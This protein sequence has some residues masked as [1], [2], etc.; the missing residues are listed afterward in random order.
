MPGKIFA[1]VGNPIL[2]SKSPEMF[3]AAF[4]KLKINAIYIRIAAFDAEEV[5][6]TADDIG[7]CGLNIT[8]PFKEE[9]KKKMRVSNSL[10]TLINTIIIDKN[11]REIDA[12]NC[13]ICKNDPKSKCPKKQ[14]LVG[15]NTD[16]A[17]VIGALKHNSCDFVGKKIIV[18]GAGGAAKAAIYALVSKKADV[19]VVN[20]TFKK[21][22]KLAQRFGCRVSKFDEIAQEL[23][24]ANILISCVPTGER[25]IPK[26][27]LRKTLSV[28]DANYSIDTALKKDAKSNNCKIID[29][30][31]WLLFQAIPCFKYF[32]GK[33][34]PVAAMRK[35]LYS[36]KKRKKNIALIGFMGSGKTAVAKELATLNGMK[37]VDIDA[38]IE[39]NMNMKIAQI[40]EDMGEREFRKI[41]NA[42]LKKALESENAIISCGGGLVLDPRNVDMLKRDCTVFWLWADITTIMERISKDDSRPLIRTKNKGDLK[43][44][45]EIAKKILEQRLFVYANACDALINTVGKKPKEIAA[46]IDYEIN[47]INKA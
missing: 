45:I 28:L 35:V 14:L 10:N 12:I 42:E 1:V 36:K 40:F 43:T 32:I 23:E 8:S 3:N 16:V 17:G 20:R 39:K 4:K 33:K 25:I 7:L 27:A 9:L 24:H 6:R 5:M 46:R 13:I 11:A 18:L 30:R 37:S 21:A 38:N 47:E 41:E 44:K 15:Y 34:A 26:S 29:G 2:H 31:E 22:K 19:V